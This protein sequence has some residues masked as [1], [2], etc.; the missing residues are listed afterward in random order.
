V[1]KVSKEY[2]TLE[3]FHEFADEGGGFLGRRN[4]RDIG[5]ITSQNEY[6]WNKRRR[7]HFFA[8]VLQ[9][10]IPRMRKIPMK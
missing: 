10:V 8:K 7:Y 4:H 3:F 6:D 2:P 9:V 5:E 1:L